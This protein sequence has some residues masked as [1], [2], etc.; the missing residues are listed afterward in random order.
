MGFPGAPLKLHKHHDSFRVS[1][2]E[3]HADLVTFGTTTT[4]NHESAHAVVTGT[5]ESAK[6]I[7]GTV[8]VTATGCGL[9]TANY[10][11]TPL[12]HS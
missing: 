7:K 5:V 2:T 10:K 1:Y 11:A 9:N 4:I 12:K 8:T 6:L 3:Q